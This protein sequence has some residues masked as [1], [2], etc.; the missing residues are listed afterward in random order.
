[1]NVLGATGGQRIEE[2]LG[3]HFVLRQAA[4]TTAL[5]VY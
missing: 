4:W 2:E 5:H 1:M 3:Q